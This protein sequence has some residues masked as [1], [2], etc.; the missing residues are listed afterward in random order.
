[1]SGYLCVVELQGVVGGERHVEAPG[2]VLGQGVAMV[3]EEERVVAEG[4]HG[5]AHLRQVVQVLQYRH[6]HTEEK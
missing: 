2:Q 5:D 4:G 1:M 3:V 6:L